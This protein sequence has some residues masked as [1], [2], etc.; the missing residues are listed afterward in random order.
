MT[1]EGTDAYRNS[2]PQSSMGKETL[3]LGDCVFLDTGVIY[4]RVLHCKKL[5]CILQCFTVN[6]LQRT[7]VSTISTELL[8][9]FYI[10]FRQ[11]CVFTV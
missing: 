7:T 2:L 10:C 11:I 9:F 5:Q 8:L 1:E 3:T 4:F 6:L